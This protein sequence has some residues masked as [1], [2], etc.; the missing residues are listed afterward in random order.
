ADGTVCDLSDLF[1]DNISALED[2][3]REK[4]KT[5]ISA[6]PDEFYPDYEGLVDFYSL[7]NR[8]Y[9]S[10]ESGFCVYYVPYELAAYAKGVLTYSVS[11]GDL[12][13]YLMFNPAYTSFAE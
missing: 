12:N 7:E 8:W 6:A 11:I 2:T 1:G 5:E 4:I 10:E 13:E 3:V 9:L